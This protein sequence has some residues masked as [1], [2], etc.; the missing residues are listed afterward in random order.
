[1]AANTEGSREDEISKLEE[2]VHAD[3]ICASQSNTSIGFCSSPSV[4]AVAQ[5]LIAEAIGTY[6]II[7]AGCGSVAVNKLYDG[8]ITFP[9]I[10]VTWGLIVMVMIYSL[11]HVSGGH[12]NPAVTIAFT[13]FRRFS[14]KLAPL[15]IIAQV[16]GSILASGTLALLLDV[17]STSY[18]GTV[19]VGSNSQSLAMEIIISFLL[20]FV[21]CGVSTDD[22]AIGELA[23]LA[24]GMTITLNVFVAGPISGASMNPARS[25]GP[26]IV[27]QVY[28]GLWVYIIGPVIGTLAGAFVYNLIRFTNKPLLQLVKSRSFLPKLRE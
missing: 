3:N 20:M 4:V 10:C 22:R 19:P 16:T 28:K 8:S 24:V 21:V 11:G 2:G 5:K 6:F 7:F 18:F 23:G 27:K 17:T 1:M 26:A 14:W 12:F 15:Y 13:I 9:G 25:I